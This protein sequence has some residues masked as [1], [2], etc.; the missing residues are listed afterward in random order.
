MSATPQ[1]A[2]GYFRAWDLLWSSIIN[3]PTIILFSALWWC[4]KSLRSRG[5]DEIVFSFR[6]VS[7]SIFVSDRPQEWDH[8]IP[9]EQSRWPENCSAWWRAIS[10]GQTLAVRCYPCGLFIFFAGFMFSESAGNREPTLI[11]QLRWTLPV[12]R[13]DDTRSTFC[14]ENW[15]FHVQYLRTF[16]TSV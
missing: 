9:I 15:Q 11:I 2:I 8:R 3:M 13:I 4:A 6:P 7:K 10:A 5:W 16:G 14:F 12:L 1:L